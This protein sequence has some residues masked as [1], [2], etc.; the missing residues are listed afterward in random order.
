MIPRKGAERP[1]S[2]C[3]YERKIVQRPH[4]LDQPGAILMTQKTI[5]IAKEGYT[6]LVLLTTLQPYPA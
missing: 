5:A 3:L 4:R 6:N 1:P 2:C